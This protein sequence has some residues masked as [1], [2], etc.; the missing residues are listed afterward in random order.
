[1]GFGASRLDV[2]LVPAALVSWIVTAAGIVWP[3]VE[4]ML[5]KSVAAA[6]MASGAAITNDM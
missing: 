4:P 2:R 3:I 6:A 1:M 5:A